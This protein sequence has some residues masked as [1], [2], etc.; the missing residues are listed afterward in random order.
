MRGQYSACG[1][2]LLNG[3]PD[4]LQVV[5][6][7]FDLHAFVW[8]VGNGGGEAISANGE[9]LAR[10]QEVSPWRY[11]LGAYCA[12]LIFVAIIDR[13][14]V[15]TPGYFL[16]RDNDSSWRGCCGG[17]FCASLFEFVSECTHAYTFPSRLM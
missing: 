3:S 7:F 8:W 6:G 15:L 11:L 5:S 9:V 14:Q 10:G 1:V 12:L 13:G 2:L 4:G 17:L 16:W